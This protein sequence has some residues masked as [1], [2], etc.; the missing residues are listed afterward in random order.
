MS[1]QNPSN[2]KGSNRI[3]VIVSLLVGGLALASFTLSFDAL[4][5]L[6]VEKQVVPQKLGWIFPLV[7]DGGIVVFSLASLEASLRKKSAKALQFLVFFVTAGS[8]FFNISHV[9][10]FSWL[11]I[12]LAATPPVLLFFSFEVLIHLAKDRMEIKYIEQ[13]E[14]AEKPLS[15][16]ARLQEVRKLHAQGLNAKEIAERIPHVSVRTIQRDMNTRANK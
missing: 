7:I 9:P 13:R 3:S 16:E 15:K 10:E 2:R 8:V 1:N 12:I 14:E 6:A 4:Q 11:A 5:K